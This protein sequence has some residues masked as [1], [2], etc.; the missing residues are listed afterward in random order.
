MPD[1]LIVAPLYKAPELI[2]DLFASLA[3]IAGEIRAVNA[4]VILINDSPDHEPLRV[5]LETQFPALA[6]VV[7][8]RLLANDENLGFVQT[9]NRGLTMA[10]EAGADVLLLNSDALLTPGA[11]AEL[12]SV[13]RLDPMISVVCPRS[14]NATICNSPYPDRF[15]ELDFEPALAAHQDLAPFLPRVSYV[16]T[17]VGFCLYI[18][19]LMIQEFGL[20]DTIYGGGYNEENDFIMR[21]NRRG[22]RATLANH[23]YAF[24]KGS[25]SFGQSSVSSADREAVNRKIL[26]GRYPEYERAVTRYFEGLDFKTEYLASGLVTSTKDRLLFDC[27]NL[28]TFYNGTFELAVNTIRAFVG[29]YGDHYEFF[30]AGNHAAVVFHGLDTLAGLTYCWNAERDMGPF[31]FCVRLAQPFSTQHLVDAAELAPIT[32]ALVLDTIAMDCLNL[33]DPD[34]HR[35]WSRMLSSTAIVGYISEFSRDQFHSRFAVPPDMVEY[36]ALC[37]TNPADYAPLGVSGSCSSDGPILL[38]GNHYSHKHIRETLALLDE[39]IDRPP[40]V[41]LGLDV[42]NQA[43][44]ESYKA[45]ELDPSVVDA[46]YEACSVVLFPSHYEGFGLPIPHGL[47]R[48]KPVIARCLPVFREI[49]ARSPDGANIH[50]FE[51]TEEMVRAACRPPAWTEDRPAESPEAVSWS[52][53]ATRL[54]EALMTARKNFSYGALRSRLEFLEGL[55]AAV[56]PKISDGAPTGT[57][58]DQGASPVPRIADNPLGFF[59]DRSAAWIEKT[60]RAIAMIGPFRSLGKAAWRGTTWGRTRTFTRLP[61]NQW[62]PREVGRLVVSLDK[63]VAD[64]ETMARAALDFAETLILGGDLEFSVPAN[65]YDLDPL[66]PQAARGVLVALTSAGFTVVSQEG[67]TTRVTTKGYL[68]SDWTALVNAKHEDNVF[69]DMTFNAIF[70]HPADG[71]G[72]LYCIEE[73]AAGRPRQEIAA[74]L[75]LSTERAFIVHQDQQTPFPRGSS[76]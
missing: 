71:M 39:Q 74:H 72:A 49:R 30:I 13:S 12:V 45:G 58:A 56:G 15:R 42:E 60:A 2:P 62:R 25:V 37:S 66:G 29:L 16:P 17:G 4:Q 35:V 1:L 33:D 59:I 36:V 64:R 73:L 34:L 76:A 67:D 52:E 9:A 10:L 21:C 41:V 47:A 8:A 23:A 54:H 69:V 22:Y 65:L 44:V 5:A 63:P 14:N 48:R 61:I 18:R 51:T 53:S 7:E 38:V 50:L 57:Q 31:T 6:S 27:N 55:R 11:L 43:G 3:A 32:T 20:F 46:L 24:H 75:L 28:S 68:T 19:R 40:V 26:L 70:N